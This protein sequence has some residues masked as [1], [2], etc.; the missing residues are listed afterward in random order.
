[1]VMGIRSLFC[2]FV[3][4]LGLGAGFFTGCSRIADL[5]GVWYEQGLNGG[6]ITIK[7]STMTFTRGD[8]SDSSS[9]SAK[10]GSHRIELI[11]KEEYFVY[12]D[13]WYETDTGELIAHTWP[14]MD[15]DGGYHVIHFARTEYE[16]P[17]A[18]VYGETVDSS[19]PDA[20]K[21]F[22]SYEVCTLT[23]DVTEPW[24]DSGDMAP[25]PPTQGSYHY[26]LVAQTAESG[27]LGSDFCR[28]IP[29]DGEWLEKLSG[30]LKESG[31]AEMNG[32]D[33]WTEGMPEETECFELTIE[34]V[35]GEIYHARANG[36]NIPTVWYEAGRELHQFLFFSFTDAGYNM[37][38]G[39]FHTTTALKRLGSASDE[40][41]PY[42]VSF[43][44]VRTEING[45]AYDYLVYS[46]Y[47]VFTVSGDA[48]ALQETLN[49]L[50][51]YY[52]D[53]AAKD[54]E[55]DNSI[56]E[57]VPKSVWKK[58]DHRTSYSFYAPTKITNDGRLFR[59]WISEGHL[60]CF[61]L[62]VHGYG[63]YPYWRFL[64]DP[65]T[66]EILSAADL[67]TSPE[68]AEDAVMKE[69]R[70]YYANSSNY[71]EVIESDEFRAKLREGLTKPEYEGGIGAIPVYDGLRVL[72]PV[73]FPGRDP[74][75]RETVLYYD[76]I[77]EILNDRYSSEW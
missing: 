13:I 19:D 10:L 70:E 63:E 38:T 2:G 36:P 44:P 69:L 27:V 16:A 56:M 17:P 71:L 9:F 53:L 76:E 42:S 43:E 72:V 62:G 30:M 22:E 48:P 41:A 57:D 55:Y 67:F 31:L 29:V 8:F 12:V 51:D 24:R 59:F 58:E 61:G 40:E 65:E 39:E 25:E 77:Q 23:L 6:T 75:T 66:G 20:P 52:K 14:H 50:S 47:P 49:E 54:L 64:I 60:N 34:F 35:S 11:P 32:T 3:M 74:Y 73:E 1:M 46:E 28:D 4:L 68:A 5:D 33:V 7:G 21:E 26:S 15:G 45:T 18:P 37:W